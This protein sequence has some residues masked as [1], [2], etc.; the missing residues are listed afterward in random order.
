MNKPPI[1]SGKVRESVRRKLKRRSS[2]WH[3]ADVKA[4]VFYGYNQVYRGR[5]NEAFDLIDILCGPEPKRKVR[6]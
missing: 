2:K 4:C 1:P 6:K 3:T 5:S